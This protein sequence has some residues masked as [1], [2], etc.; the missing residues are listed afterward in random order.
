M[1]PMAGGTLRQSMGYNETVLFWKKCFRNQIQIS[2]EATTCYNTPFQMYMLGYPYIILPQQH[3]Q[4][5]YHV[6]A[7]IQFYIQFFHI[8]LPKN[9]LFYNSINNLNNIWY[10]YIR[11]YSISH[12]SQCTPHKLVLF[13]RAFEGYR[14]MN[15]FD[16]IL[17]F[18]AKIQLFLIYVRKIPCT[19]NSCTNYYNVLL[20]DFTLP[21]S[22]CPFFFN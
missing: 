21:V 3:L 18:M 11:I 15:I 10:N 5:L 14:I 4:F 7:N 2:K 8:A 9:M 16:C 6:I 22:M 12:L 19:V 1:C 13:R 20:Q 17:F